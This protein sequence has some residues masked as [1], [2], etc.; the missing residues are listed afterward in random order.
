MKIILKSIILV[1]LTEGSDIYWALL[2]PS[3]YIVPIRSYLTIVTPLV[4]FED[5]L[6]TK[7]RIQFRLVVLITIKK[8]NLIILFFWVCVR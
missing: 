1:F 6:T 3:K 2:V 4:R 5:V 7:N 8:Y